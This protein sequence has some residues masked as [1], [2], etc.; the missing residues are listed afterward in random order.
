L[1]IDVHDATSNAQ[2]H[3]QPQNG[4]ICFGTTRVSFLILEGSRTRSLA[5]AIWK[6]LQRNGASS[7][8][9]EPPDVGAPAE[10]AN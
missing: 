2:I 1:Y 7:C 4:P 3:T 6:I 8:R 5:P 10:T 9:P